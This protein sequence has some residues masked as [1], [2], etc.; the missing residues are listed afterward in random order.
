MRFL[1]VRV[2]NPYCLGTRCQ[3]L[4]HLPGKFR[5]KF[6]RGDDFDNQ[7]RR[8]V[9]RTVRIDLLWFALSKQK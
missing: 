4:V 5:S 9:D 3:I 2:K 7:C 1:R 8:A 6:S